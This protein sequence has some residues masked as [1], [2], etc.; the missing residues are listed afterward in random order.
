[1]VRAFLRLILIALASLTL[2]V[3]AVFLVRQ[4]GFRQ[5]FAPPPHPWYQDSSWN[6]QV[7][8]KNA[9]CELPKTPGPEWIVMVSVH[10]AGQVWKVEC[11]GEQPD[12]LTWLKES[13]HK[14]WLLNI[15]ASETYDL[16]EFVD[17]VAAFDKEKQ[18]AVYSSSQK[19]ARYLRKKAPQWL[20]AADSVSLLRLK[21]FAALW[22]E[23]ATEFWPDF[24]IANADI[25]S[26]SSLSVREAEELIRR[27]KRVLWD[28]TQTQER[29]PFPVQGFLTTRPSTN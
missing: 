2:T 11:A 26:S 4:L 1:M 5:N 25:N 8:K 12:L 23:T 28:Q 20:F 17:R 14:R 3:L 6:V 24:V 15:E 16:D 9:P 21:V 29:P 27:H 13:D 18:F 22:I 7:L 10:R 19:V